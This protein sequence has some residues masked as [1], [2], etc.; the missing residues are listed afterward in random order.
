MQ[1]NGGADVIRDSDGTELSPEITEAGYGIYST[2][3]IIRGH[4]PWAMENLDKLQQTFLVTEPKTAVEHYLELELLKEFF[5]EQFK[6]NDSAEALGYW[7]VYDRTTDKEVNK[8][9]WSYDKK[10]GV[11]GIENCVLWH[12]YTVSFLAYRIWEE[13]S[14]YNHITNNWDK[15]HLIPIDPVYAETQVY[16]I[17]WMKEWCEEHPATTV[18]RFTSMFYNFVWIWGSDARK[19]KFIYRLG[20]LRFYSESSC[21]TQFRTEIWICTYRRGFCESRE[22][23]GNPYAANKTKKRLDGIY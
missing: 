4:N 6:I 11:V 14:M 2:I 22:I 17:N 19:P 23:S 16:L 1:K 20:L 7:Q 21:F 18:V 5:Q 12:K 9:N 15:E 10:K 13:I 3:C 8:E